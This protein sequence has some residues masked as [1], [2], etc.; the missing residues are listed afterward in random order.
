MRVLRRVAVPWEMLGG[1]RYASRLQ[2]SHP[3]PAVPRHQFGVTA[4]AADADHWVVGSGVDVDTG[5]EVHSASGL[6]Q[7]PADGGRG[8]ACRVEVVEP[9]EHSIARERCAGSCEEP[10]DVTAFL[11]DSDDRVRVLGHDC[12]G[13]HLQLFDR[14]DVLR[15]EAD[16]S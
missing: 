13:Q 9:A 14:G 10:R 15:V 6:T 8:L 1:C 7:R 11:V 16:T 4:E 12:V 3:G 5:G 2:A